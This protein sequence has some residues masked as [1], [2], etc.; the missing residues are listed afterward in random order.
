MMMLFWTLWSE[1]RDLLLPIS[2]RIKKFAPSWR[3]LTTSEICSAKISIKYFTQSLRI[4]AANFR[5]LPIS[6]KYLKFSYTLL[7]LTRLGKKELLKISTDF[8]ADLF[9]K[10][11][12]FVISLKNMFQ[13]LFF[14]QIIYHEKFFITVLLRNV[15]SRNLIQ[16][17]SNKYSKCSTCSC[18]WRKN[19][20]QKKTLLFWTCLGR[21]DRQGVWYW[22]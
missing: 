4:T 15:L 2:C 10:V 5:P 9:Q 7:T 19:F 17:W 11:N 1:K 14:G 6:K 13:K 12:P 18:N 22:G 21:Y 3:R 8:F 20:F 16:P